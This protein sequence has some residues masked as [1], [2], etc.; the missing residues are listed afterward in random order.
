MLVFPGIRQ[1]IWA[2]SLDLVAK[3]C[4]LILQTFLNFG[5]FRLKVSKKPNKYHRWFNQLSKHKS[6][7]T[8]E[9][10][11]PKFPTFTSKWDWVPFGY[12]LKTITFSPPLFIITVTPCSLKLKRFLNNSKSK[13]TKHSYIIFL[14]LPFL[15]V[16]F[17]Y[18]Y[19]F[20]TF[21]LK[22]QISSLS[23]YPLFWVNQPSWGLIKKALFRLPVYSLSIS[24]SA[25]LEIFSDT[26][27]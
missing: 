7:F 27:P 26:L 21:V 5:K 18:F 24:P 19:F 1:R 11:I 15:M 6:I 17:F 20:L 3:L 25:F 9:V 2:G 14:W 16:A 12:L 10:K 22:K 4:T 23:W 8:A 13:S